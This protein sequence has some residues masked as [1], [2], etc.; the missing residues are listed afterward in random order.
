MQAV[1][2]LF[3]LDQMLLLMRGGMDC[4]YRMCYVFHHHHHHHHLCASGTVCAGGKAAATPTKSRGTARTALTTPPSSN[5]DKGEA[6]LCVQGSA[7]HAAVV[8]ESTAAAGL[9]APATLKY[10]TPLS[11]PLQPP[12]A[13]AVA[14]I[15]QEVRTGPDQ[16]VPRA[17]SLDTAAAAGAM[18]VAVS[19][20]RPAMDQPDGGD[21][22]GNAA[23]PAGMLPLLCSGGPCG[24]A[25]LLAHGRACPEA[26][27]RLDAV[28]SCRSPDFSTCWVACFPPRHVF[29]L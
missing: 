16:S 21:K 8:N 7:E 11:A 26:R 29:V 15:G 14:G 24:L 25:Y 2:A 19:V 13:A 22:E 6:K 3:S 12:S 10:G 23:S 1:Q 17:A 20:A 5:A 28:A 9:L 27:V 4:A 18:P